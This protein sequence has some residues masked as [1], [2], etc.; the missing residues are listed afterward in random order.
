MNDKKHNMVKFNLCSTYEYS[1]WNH[2][3]YENGTNLQKWIP[4]TTLWWVELKEIWKC[5]I[6]KWE[7]FEDK[8]GGKVSLVGDIDA[9]KCDGDL[10][11]IIRSLIEF[12]RHWDVVWEGNI[13]SFDESGTFIYNAPNFNKTQYVDS[14]L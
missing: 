1:G 7:T 5:D 10:G 9:S 4:M 11:L 8:C 3:K 6:E 12:A 2:F 14:D 13:I